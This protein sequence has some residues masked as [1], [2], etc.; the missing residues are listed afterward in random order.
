MMML[1]TSNVP[2]ITRKQWDKIHKDY[3]CH[4]DGKPHCFLGCIQ[5]GGGTILAE[6]EII[7]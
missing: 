3:K 5:D 4:I 1:V 2:K 6:V 7:K